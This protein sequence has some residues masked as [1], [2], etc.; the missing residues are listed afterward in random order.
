MVQILFSVTPQVSPVSLCQRAKGR[1]QYVLRKA[2]VKVDFSRKVSFRSLG[3]NTSCVVEK[4]IEG[5]V[6]KEDF[7]D[8]R[9]R[10]RMRQFTVICDDVRLADPSESNSGRYWYNLHIVIVAVNR[11]RTTNPE[12]LGR[13]RDEAFRIAVAGANRIAAISVMPDHV[14]MAI[15]GNI[16]ESAEEIAL[17]FQNGLAKVVGCRAWQD[18]YYAGTFSEYDLDV[19]RKMV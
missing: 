6:S 14:H 13:I 8:P 2:G 15:R 12:M 7:A 11:F 3:E 19:I 1:L 10:D 4:Y 18:G 9:F 17:S 5:Q 16:E